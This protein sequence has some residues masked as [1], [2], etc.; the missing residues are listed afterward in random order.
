MDSG[1]ARVGRVTGSLSVLMLLLLC[2]ATASAHTLY[3]FVQRIDG[4]AIHGRAYFPGDVPA[5]NSDV[6][7]RDASGRELG[8]TTTDDNGSFTFTARNRVDHYL[9]AETSDGHSSRPYR[10]PASLLPDSLAAAVPSGDGGPQVASQ[11]KRH[12]RRAGIL[13]RQ[14]ERTRREQGPVD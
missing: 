13:S 7:A 6:I 9:V 14:G 11:V 2:H 8:R 3:V 12:S 1:G 4:A 5:Q 10:V